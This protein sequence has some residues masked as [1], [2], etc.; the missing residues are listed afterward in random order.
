MLP[1]AEY[2]TDTVN[3]V[4]KTIESARIGYK[5]MEGTRIAFDKKD[6]IRLKGR[7]EDAGFSVH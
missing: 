5:R 3:I 4:L 2:N 6:W 7:L 1:L